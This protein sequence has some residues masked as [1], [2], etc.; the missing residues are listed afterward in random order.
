MREAGPAKPR[1]A[2]PV[3]QIPEGPQ[4]WP[5]VIRCT[6]SV[7]P[8]F[9]GGAIGKRVPVLVEIRKD[10]RFN[11]EEIPP[12]AW[13]QNLP[14]KVKQAVQAALAEAAGEVPPVDRRLDQVLERLDKIERQLKHLERQKSPS[15]S[16]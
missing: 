13:Q 15:R 7:A 9:E 16:Q 14:D 5:L 11:E 3:P 2:V 1:R 10:P 12:E 4:T 8:I 6:T